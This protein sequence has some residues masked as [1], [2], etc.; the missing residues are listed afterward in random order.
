MAQTAYVNIW[1][2]RVG[3]VFWDIETGVAS[4]EYEPDFLNSGWD[5]SPLQM[6]LSEGKGRVFSFPEHRDVPAFQ[7]LPGLLADALPDKYGSEMINAWLVKEGRP[8]DS[9]NPV[10]KL[11]FMG[12]RGMGALEFEPSTAQFI[13]AADELEI[14]NMVDIANSILSD[15]EGFITNLTEDEREAI[16]D[17]IHLST[18][19]GGARAKAVIAFNQ[20]TNEVRSGQVSA[21]EGF[22]QWLIKFDGI[23]EGELLE[24]KGYGRTEMAYH[25]MAKA[26]GVNMMECQLLE[27]HGRAHFMTKRFDRISGVD[28]LHFQTFCAMQHYDFNQTSLYSYEHLFET[29]RSLGLPYTDA[30]QL[31]TRMV[32]NIMC[33][34]CDDHAKN[35]GFLMD[36]TGQWRLAPAYDIC[37]AYK[38]GHRWLDRHSLSVNGKYEGILR[39]DL[40]EIAKR[41]NIKKPKDIIQNIEQARGNWLGFADDV[42]VD[43]AKA[44][45]I[46]S[47]YELF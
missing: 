37:Y 17:V 5:L 26:A 25:Y 29:M 9:L 43:S 16:M 35:F 15:R 13:E 24:S 47:S 4:F 40:L 28:K 12:Q 39:D 10:E 20:S 8:V 42:K 19:A 44:K 14:S 41:M 32:F 45:A 31:Y 21:P 7:G 46:M 33:R 34:N 3:A 36:Q 1:D 38:P 22:T 11:C 6:A 30:Q 27:E 2:Q 18:S 23:K